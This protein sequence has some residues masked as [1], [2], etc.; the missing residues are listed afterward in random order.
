MIK[1]S[2]HVDK[3][4]LNKI[5]RIPSIFDSIVKLDLLGSR[6]HS[7]QSELMYIS[8]TGRHR[9]VGAYKRG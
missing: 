9:G 5:D 2:I 1:K 7:I 8:F 3:A 6:E 4:H